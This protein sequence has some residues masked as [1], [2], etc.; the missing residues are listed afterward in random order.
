[1]ADLYT[2][3]ADGMRRIAAAV[4]DFERQ[5]KN[6]DTPTPGQRRTS[7][8]IHLVGRNLSTIERGSPAA[9]HVYTITVLGRATDGSWAAHDET[10]TCEE[11]GMI[12][13]DRCPV[14]IGSL[15]YQV[16]DSG[17]WIYDGHDCT[18]EPA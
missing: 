5:L 10:R 1:M 11:I 9:P 6:L 15:C 4:R 16:W 17:A 12:H 18:V 3:D 13:P 14:P 2:F 7:P 8:R